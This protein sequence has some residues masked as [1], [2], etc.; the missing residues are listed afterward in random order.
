MVQAGK[1]AAL[2]PEDVPIVPSFMSKCIMLNCLVIMLYGVY[3]FY[4]QKN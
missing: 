3:V 4:V 1:N 2:V